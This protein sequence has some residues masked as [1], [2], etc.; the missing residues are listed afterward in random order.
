MIILVTGDFG[1]GKDTFANMLLTHLGIDMAQLV[2]S[3][4]TREPRYDDEITHSFETVED[5][6]EDKEWGRVVAHTVIGGHHYW[7]T[8]DQFV[9]FLNGF[10][11]YVVDDI[12]IRDVQAAN[13]DDTFVIEV[14]RPSW[15][16]DI[17]EE[18]KNRKRESGS[19]K[20]K[21]DYR[22][23][24]DKT[25]SY[26]DTIAKDVSLMLLRKRLDQIEG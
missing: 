13:I 7:T 24:N 12:G 1:V 19:Y 4:T 26:L 23:I 10:S 21:S 3:K 11:I 5:Y 6:E 2:R 14:V 8:K 25:I 17:D 9:D 20:F 15:L 22:V 18:R 16:I